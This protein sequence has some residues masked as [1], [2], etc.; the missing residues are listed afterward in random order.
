[1]KITTNVARHTGQVQ[2]VSDIIKNHIGEEVKPTSSI[3]KDLTLTEVVFGWIN[4][5]QTVPAEERISS[6]RITTEKGAVNLTY[7]NHNGN[8]KIQVKTDK[9]KFVIPGLQA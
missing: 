4:W 5:C 7:N 3:D 9:L 2:M 6:K 8:V 1:M